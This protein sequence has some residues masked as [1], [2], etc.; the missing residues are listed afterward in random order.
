MIKEE[1]E[2]YGNSPLF[3]VNLAIDDPMVGGSVSTGETVY[4]IR[5]SKKTN[6][7]SLLT[8]GIMSVVLAAS[9]AALVAVIRSRLLTK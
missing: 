5:R 9:A 8:K 2:L 4:I 1:Y 6:G 7:S 3:G